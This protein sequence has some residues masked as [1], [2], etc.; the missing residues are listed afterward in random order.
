MTEN[1]V[2]FIVIFLPIF[3]VLIVLMMIRNIPHMIRAVFRVWIVPW[4]KLLLMAIT[5]S[6]ICWFVLTIE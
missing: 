4:T 2:D 3:G 6:L 5:M 1:F